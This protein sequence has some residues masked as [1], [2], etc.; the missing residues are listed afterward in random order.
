MNEIEKVVRAEARRRA[1]RALEHS[2]SVGRT[3]FGTTIVSPKFSA[4][5][6][7]A[8]LKA[9]EDVAVSRLRCALIELA[10]PG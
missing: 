5:D 9:A 10:L 4:E 8:A 6:R 7:E 2:E 3:H 1:E